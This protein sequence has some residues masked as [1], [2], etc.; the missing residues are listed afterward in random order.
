MLF[1]SEAVHALFGYEA[2]IVSG[3]LCYSLP[4]IDSVRDEAAQAW[5]FD[6]D[7]IGFIKQFIYLTPVDSSN[8]PHCYVPGTHLPGVKSDILL[9]H[10]YERISDDMMSLYQPQLHREVLGDAGTGF[11][12]ST[13]CWHKGQSVMQGM[14]AMIIMEYSVSNFQLDVRQTKK[15][16]LKSNVKQKLQSL[17]GRLNS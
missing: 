6:L 17:L 1:R 14:R 3:R 5:H 11:L 12:G 8:G 4:S 9:S 13:L 10:K 2:T 15:E 16:L 7:G